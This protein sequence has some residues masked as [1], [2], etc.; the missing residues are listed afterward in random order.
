MLH[1]I[2]KQIWNT[3]QWPV[4]WKMSVFIPVSN[5]GNAKE[6]S[7]YLTIVFIS[8]AT[9]V[10]HKSL[11]AWFQ[12]Y[13]NHEFPV[14]QDG[15]RKGRE[16]R[17]QIARHLLDHWKS[18]RLPEKIYFCFIDYAKAFDCVDHNKLWKILKEMGLSD[19]LYP[20]PEKCW[21]LVKK[22]L[23]PDMGQQPVTKLGKE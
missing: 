20:P 2:C 17:D 22:Q 18:K 13:M 4:D 15:F 8:H 7:N 14:V 5:K 11:Q 12:Q 21:M 6:W 19:H 23:G 3:Q 16:T 1:S 9:K 10:M